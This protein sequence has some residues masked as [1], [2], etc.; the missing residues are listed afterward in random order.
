MQKK[1]GSKKKTYKENH[2]VEKGIVDLRSQSAVND[3]N[4]EPVICASPTLFSVVIAVLFESSE[5]SKVKFFE[6]VGYLFSLWD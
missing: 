4:K 5:K 3:Q 2:V 1:L 6:C